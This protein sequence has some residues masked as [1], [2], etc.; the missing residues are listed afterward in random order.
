MAL[1]TDLHIFPNKELFAT[2]MAEILD[3]AVPLSGI[4]QGCEVSFN[5]G[6]GTLSIESGRMLIRGRLGVI[7]EGGDIAIPTLTGTSNVACRLIA[8]CNLSTSETPFT[9]EIA[10]P[11]TIEEYTTRRIDSESTFNTQDGFDYLVLGTA[12]VNPISGKVVSWTPESNLDIKNAIKL[13]SNRFGGTYLPSGTNINDLTIKD[14]GWWAYSR[15]DMSGTFPLTD[16]YGIIGHIQG[17]SNGFATQ[18][19]RSNSQAGNSHIM[20]VRHKVSGSWGAWQRYASENRTVYEIERIDNRYC[21][22]TDI[23]YLSAGLKGGYLYLRGNL[24]LSANIPIG[25]AGVGIARINGWNAFDGCFINVPSQN[26]FGT[27]VVQVSA[28]G[29]VTISNYSVEPPQSTWTFAGWYRF[30]LI[31]PVADGYE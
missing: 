1:T 29:V 10:S 15:A 31:V 13:N 9:I 30:N 6:A 16:T 25:T 18:I 28:S 7:E 22:T 20:Y 11:A 8:V 19:I 26:G 21:T 23:G 24:H 2:D 17:T 14:S 27:L 3:T 4:V 5:S 12:A